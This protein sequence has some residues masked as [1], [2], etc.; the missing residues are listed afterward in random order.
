[1]DAPRRSKAYYCDIA[2]ETLKILDE[3]VYY[4]DN[5]SEILIAADLAAAVA[6]TTTLMPRS[7]G[8]WNTP[9]APTPGPPTTFSVSRHTTLDGCAQM[10]ARYTNV[11]A[12]NFASARHPGGGFLKGAN[13][14]EESLARSSGLY[15]CIRESPMYAINERNT[16]AC[17]YSHVMIYSPAVPV[18]GDDRG[19]LLKKPF[20]VS[21]IS[22]PAPNAYEAAKRRVTPTM[23][24]QTLVDRIDHILALAVEHGHD[25]IVLSAWGCGVFGNN[26]ESVAS[27]FQSM[28]L[29]KYANCFRHVHY[30]TTGQAE[31]DAFSRVLMATKK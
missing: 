28:L 26:V 29:G 14:Q 27:I 9:P 1:M 21:F 30:A 17:L 18:F 4:L 12:L 23:I 6:G 31:Y 19:K 11:V 15:A 22:A 20:K 10:V 13:A 16:N 8:G 3:G 25:A 5:G 24:R 2:S 7:I